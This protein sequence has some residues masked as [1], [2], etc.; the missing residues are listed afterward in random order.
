[1]CLYHEK[2]CACLPH[3]HSAVQGI[4]LEVL[5][6]ILQAVQPT[7]V[8]LLQTG[9]PTKDLP[10]GNF[11]EEAPSLPTVILTL[12]AVPALDGISPGEGHHCIRWGLSQ[13]CD[14]VEAGTSGRAAV[15]SAPTLP[16]AA[17]PARATLARSRPD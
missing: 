8:I 5:T 2:S 10:V 14:S 16:V 3:L 12:P 15:I 1:M 13:S 11:W 17:L 4:G 7:H 6:G 9:N